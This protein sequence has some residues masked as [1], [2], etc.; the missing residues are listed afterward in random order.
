MRYFSSHI[1]TDVT[2]LQNKIKEICGIEK[3]FDMRWIK[4]ASKD[5]SYQILIEKNEELDAAT[6][7]MLENCKRRQD[8]MENNQLCYEIDCGEIEVHLEFH[9]CCGCLD[10]LASTYE[11]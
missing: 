8:Q 10:W 5:S 11:I 1:F 9:D 2:L 7:F 3:N 6:N 4:P